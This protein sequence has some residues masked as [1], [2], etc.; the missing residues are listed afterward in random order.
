MGNSVKSVERIMSFGEVFSALTDIA[1]A[2]SKLFLKALLFYVAP[3]QLIRIVLQLDYQYNSVNSFYRP[4]PFFYTTSGIVSAVIAFAAI[5]IV[6]V[7]AFRIVAQHTENGTEIK[8]PSELFRLDKS[9]LLSFMLY[10]FIFGII[11]AISV[12]VAFF[13]IATIGNLFLAF[14]I[15]LGFIYWFMYISTSF[16][17]APF[18]IIAEKKNGFKSI[19]RSF[20][21]VDGNRWFTF[22]L[23]VLTSLMTYICIFGVGVFSGVATA[24]LL[25]FGSQNAGNSF[26]LIAI[27]QTVVSIISVVG[28]AIVTMVLAVQYFNL[29]ERRDATRLERRVELIGQS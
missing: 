14:L 6:S 26:L 13:L 27:V 10:F 24:F 5:V 17:M 7:I 28:T 25:R 19:D 15:V 2:N 20:S 29:R 11:L 22:G 3:I 4:T 12:L 21:L 8:T 23:M 1:R 9:M 16:S 18:V